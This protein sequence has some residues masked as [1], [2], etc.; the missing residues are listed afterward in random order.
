MQTSPERCQEFGTRQNKLHIYPTTCEHQTRQTVENPLTASMAC[1]AYD[2]HPHHSANS[3]DLNVCL[4]PDH[5]TKLLVE[6][7]PPLTHHPV[8]SPWNV[9]SNLKD[10]FAPVAAPTTPWTGPLWLEDTPLTCH[11]RSFYAQFPA[12]CW[13]PHLN[14]IFTE[15]SLSEVFASS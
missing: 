14:P 2:R 1:V 4:Q 5:L 6:I 7:M 10:V 8:Y 9:S 3:H 15:M 13:R 12:T 11:D